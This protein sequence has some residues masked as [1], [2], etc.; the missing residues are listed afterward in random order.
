[1]ETHKRNPN[2]ECKICK[3]PVYRRPVEIAKNKGSVFCG[4]VCYGIACRKEVPC[5]ICKKLILAG[6]NK[7][8]CSRACANK[9]REGIRYKTGRPLKGNVVSQRLLKMRLLGM[10]GE[11][12]ERCDYNKI[13]ILQVHHKDKNRKNNSIENLALICPNCHFEEHY[14]KK[15]WLR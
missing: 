2:I 7:K 6:D 8:T 14:L 13:E 15:S 11:K 5:V 4:S 3:K 1:M 9:H 10:R 12:C